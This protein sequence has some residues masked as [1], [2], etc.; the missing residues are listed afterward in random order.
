MNPLIYVISIIIVICILY[1]FSENIKNLWGIREGFVNLTGKDLAQSGRCANYRVNGTY[2]RDG[3]YSDGCPTKTDSLEDCAN[4][5]GEEGGVFSYNPNNG[6]CLYTKTNEPHLKSTHSRHSPFDPIKGITSGC[7]PEYW[8][9]GW[10][11]YQAIKASVPSNAKDKGTIV[12][13]FPPHTFP[14]SGDQDYRAKTVTGTVVKGSAQ[15]FWTPEKTIPTDSGPPYILQFQYLVNDQGWGN[16]TK[17]YLYL[18]NITKNKR[19]TIYDDHSRGTDCGTQRCKT[20]CGKKD[21][22]QWVSPGDKIK[23][24]FWTGRY[25]SGHS[26]EWRWYRKLNLTYNIPHPPILSRRQARQPISTFQTFQGNCMPSSTLILIGKTPKKPKKGFVM[27]NAKNWRGKWDNFVMSF[28]IK[29]ISQGSGWRNILHNTFSGTNGDT[30]GY[31][32]YPGIWIHDGSYK[33]HIKWYN[34]EGT[35]PSYPLTEG[36]KSRITLIINGANYTCI[37]RDQN[38]EIKYQKTQRLSGHSPPNNPWRDGSVYPLLNYGGSM[39]KMP[40]GQSK[41]GEC[42]GDCDS[43]ANCGWPDSG[44]KCY[45]RSKSSDTVPGCQISDGTNKEDIGTHD[46]CYYPNRQSFYLSSPW[47]EPFDC[48]ISELILDSN[49]N[50][51]TCKILEKQTRPT[52]QNA[53]Y[54]ACEQKTFIEHHKSAIAMGG[55]LV[56]IHNEAENEAIRKILP[57]CRGVWI[58]AVRKRP[59]GGN[60]NKNWTWTD[61]SE[62]DYANWR[63][64]EPNDCCKAQTQNMGE[65]HVVMQKNDGKWNDIYHKHNNNVKQFSAVYKLNTTYNKSWPPGIVRLNTDGMNSWAASKKMCEGEANSGNIVGAHGTIASRREVLD[66]IKGKPES[67]DSWTPVSD[68]ANVWLQVGMRNDRSGITPSF[69]MTHQEIPDVAYTKSGEAAKPV[70]GSKNEQKTFRKSLFCKKPPDGMTWDNN[71]EKFVKAKLPDQT[72][73]TGSLLP[74]AITNQRRLPS[75]ITT[76]KHSTGEKT[77]AVGNDHKFKPGQRVVIG[78]P[79]NT[80]RRT[81]IKA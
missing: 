74:S 49:I 56:S 37:I 3:Q 34:N 75:A 72:S 29:P 47:Y 2:V 52:A 30:K 41:L 50:D 77:L 59:G 25:N 11:F 40:T 38:D 60:S 73:S 12:N 45:E 1:H 78:V 13:F 51:P 65:V 16:Q 67:G 42:E 81:I 36:Q 70:W 58:G 54:F 48:E 71:L 79:P 10:K 6:G 17:S 28:V 14:K 53:I 57:P 61:G 31:S 20:N 39:E 66:F 32:R 8:S 33:L 68:G 55:H 24:M 80:E 63:S 15:E 26:L 64:G 69:A 9:G 19:N 43:D 35:D 7:K 5:F 18:Q 4:M 62:W 27:N 44:L 23:L 76:Q 22:S 21:I 46:Y